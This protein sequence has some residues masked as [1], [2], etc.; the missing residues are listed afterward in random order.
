[1]PL[2]VTSSTVGRDAPLATVPAEVD[3]DQSGASQQSAR[4]DASG[5]PTTDSASISNQGQKLAALG[6]QGAQL[7]AV[8]EAEELARNLAARMAQ[9]AQQATAAQGRLDPSR[10][11]QLLDG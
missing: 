6:D 8:A 7:R 3:T 11:A 4:T 5:R 10:V 9:N 2:H 1:M